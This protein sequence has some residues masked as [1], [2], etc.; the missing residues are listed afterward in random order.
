MMYKCN[1]DETKVKWEN[2]WN[3]KNIGR[4]LMCV[5]AGK[6]HAIDLNKNRHLNPRIWMINTSMLKGL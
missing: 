2:Y 6:E 4:P 1:W 5:I 3:R